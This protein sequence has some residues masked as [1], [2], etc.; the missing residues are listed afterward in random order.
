MRREEACV[1]CACPVAM[2]M[3]EEEEDKKKNPSFL[4]LLCSIIHTSAVV[5]NGSF[6]RV[7]G[8]CWDRRTRQADSRIKIFKYSTIENPNIL[9]PSVWEGGGGGGSIKTHLPPIPHHHHQTIRVKQPWCCVFS[10]TWKKG[11]MGRSH[12]IT[13]HARPMISHKRGKKIM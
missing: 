12:A 13:T 1:C 5:T 8:D 9:C 6:S 10:G 4:P 2:Q 7:Q 3:R 11:G